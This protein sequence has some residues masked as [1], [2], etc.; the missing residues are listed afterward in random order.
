MSRISKL[1]CN[2]CPVVAGVPAEQESQFVATD[3]S[4]Q[5]IAKEADGK[6]VSGG[7]A[8]NP[9]P[10]FA[11]IKGVNYCALGTDTEA[12]HGVV[13]HVQ[14][15]KGRQHEINWQWTPDFTT[16]RGE[17]HSAGIGSGKSDYIVCRKVNC[18][19]VRIGNQS[20]YIAGLGKPD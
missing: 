17:K 20:I 8:V 18:G 7:P 10:S 1:N 2:R 15:I 19:K 12:R 16:V 14:G 4:N 11:T 13:A 9:L 5:T 6:Q 3:D